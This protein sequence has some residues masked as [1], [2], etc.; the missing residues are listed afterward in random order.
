MEERRGGEEEE[1]EEGGNVGKVKALTEGDIAEGEV[2][3]RGSVSMRRLLLIQFEEWA[4]V[5]R[6]DDE[7]ERGEL[8]WTGQEPRE[9]DDQGDEEATGDGPPRDASFPPKEPA[10]FELLDLL[11]PGVPSGA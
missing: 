8:E 3:E 6:D 11:P 4:D 1:E 7:V 10:S 5:A 9:E 2:E